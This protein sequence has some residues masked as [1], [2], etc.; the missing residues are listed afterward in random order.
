[1]SIYPQVWYCTSCHTRMNSLVCPSCAFKSEVARAPKRKPYAITM[2]CTLTGADW[3][4]VR[5]LRDAADARMVAERAL[6]YDTR[7]HR[8]HSRLVEV[9]EATADEIAQHKAAIAAL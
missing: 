9:R 1:M 5:H 8:N 7:F 3:H 2:R 4:M 6:K